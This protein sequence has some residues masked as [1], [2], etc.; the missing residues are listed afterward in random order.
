VAAL[1]RRPPTPLPDLAPRSPL[2]EIL[3]AARWAPSGDNSQPWRF[4]V[5]GEE[6]VIVH[7]AA[8]DANNVYQYRDA[9]P[10]L[11]AGGAL[12]E[13]LRLAATAW[14]RGMRWTLESSAT[15]DTQRITVDF[16]PVEGMEPD[17]L[18]AQI[19]LRSVNRRPYRW[20][21]LTARQKAELA[22][23][24][25][26]TLRIDWFETLGQRWK[27]ARLGARATDI[28]L[29]A[30]ETFVI[31]QQVIDWVRRFSPDGL[32]SGTLG[33]AKATLPIM[34][35]AMR[36]WSRLSRLNRFLGTWST[37]AQLDHV[38]GVASGGFFAMRLKEPTPAN[39]T[40]AGA[41]H[42][43]R[44][45]R[46][47]QAVQRFWL[48]ATRLGLS[49]QPQLA[50][51][52]FADYGV[53]GTPFTGDPALLAK[54]R[55]LGQRFTATLGATP[56][57]VIFIGRIGTAAPGLPRPRSTRRGVAEMSNELRHPSEPIV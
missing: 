15:P 50:T 36:D 29:R 3:H 26:D 28:R 51:I 23:S 53:R 17:P 11:L 31:H 2:G 7:L 6:R 33:L 24:L 5:V 14:G 27:I 42:V 32:P 57:D 21:R 40:E 55:D 54:A 49:M 46:A 18:F 9:E 52:A 20:L 12:L 16:F 47:G 22:V 41:D 45:L 1:S 13:S 44:M 4:E 43:T 37:Q 25:G 35:W 56:E 19:H 38:P 48:T 8:T 10:T 39:G 34:R 30:P